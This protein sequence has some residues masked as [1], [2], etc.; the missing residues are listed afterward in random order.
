MTP[1]CV[2]LTLFGFKGIHQPW[3]F[4]QM[5]MGRF[6]SQ[7]PKGLRFWKMLGTGEGLGFSLKPNFGRY[8]FLGVWDSKADADLFLEKS[9]FIRHYRKHA[10]EVWTIALQPIKAHGL[11][12]GINPFS[13]EADNSNVSNPVA[14]LTRAQIRVN[15]LKR[16]WQFV[17]ATSKALEDAEGLQASIG[18]GEMPFIKQATFSIWKDQAAMQ[19]FAYAQRQHQEVIRKTRSEDWY[20]E[21]LFARFSVEEASGSWNGR[22]PINSLNQ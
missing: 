12:D 5:G 11:W 13:P 20:T 18:L 19:N 21:E 7:N 2:T 8:G 22:Y 15:K 4:A 17:P 16:F 3:A 10:F 1:P 9:K 6:Q 14:V